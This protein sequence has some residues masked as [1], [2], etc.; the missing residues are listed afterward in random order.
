VMSPLSPVQVE[1]WLAHGPKRGD[2]NGKYS[3]W[4]LAIA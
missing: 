1:L 3:G 2:H 4:Q